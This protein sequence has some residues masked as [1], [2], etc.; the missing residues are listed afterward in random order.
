MGRNDLLI[1]TSE[2]ARRMGVSAKVVRDMCSSGKI[3]CAKI[4]RRWFVN[5]EALLSLAR[6]NGPEH[7]ER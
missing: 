6:M 7:V 5:P 1:T 3:P 2:A 4:G